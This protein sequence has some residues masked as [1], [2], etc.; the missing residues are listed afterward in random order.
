VKALVRVGICGRCG[1]CM[2]LDPPPGGTTHYYAQTYDLLTG[3]VEEDDLFNVKPDGTPV[4]RQEIELENLD[5]LVPLPPTGR[6][7]DYGCGKGAFLRRFL[8]R[9]PTW[10]GHGFDMSEKYRRFVEKVIRPDH[11][12]VAS[13]QSLVDSGLRFDLIVMFQVTEHLEQPREILASLRTLLGPGGTLHVT[14]PNLLA[15]SVDMF[16]AD[17]LSHFTA[18]T[19][20]LLLSRAGFRRAVGSD[21]HQAGQITAAYRSDPDPE[22]TKLN[23]LGRS[24]QTLMADRVGREVS[25]WRGFGERSRE[26]IAAH[27]KTAIYGAGAAGTYVLSAC[28]AVRANVIGYIDRNPFK[29]GTQHFGLPIFAPEGAPADMD[30]IVAALPPQRARQIIEEAGLTSRGIPILMPE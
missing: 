27:P 16:V 23:D 15:Y 1:H 28:D 18:A 17:H 8:A 25:F 30:G 5:A 6:I 19:L 2:T 21:I 24:Y 22:T 10:T 20:D 11:F 4:Y 9:H 29:V 3:S 14:V 7:L 13:L 12:T 26:F